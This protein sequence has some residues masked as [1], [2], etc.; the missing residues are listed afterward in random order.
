MA[1]KKYKR[2]T[3]AEKK[4]NKEFRE[5]LREKGII[6]PVKPRLNRKKFLQ[7][8]FREYDEAIKTY[9]D[10]NYLAKAIAWTVGRDQDK[11]ITTEQV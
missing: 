10:M 6:P 8:T 5:E 1:K 2:M 3:A 4:W 11:N 9:S 7:E